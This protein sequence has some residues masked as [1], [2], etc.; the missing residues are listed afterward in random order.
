MSTFEEFRSI[1]PIASLFYPPNLP[2]SS[3]FPPFTPLSPP[4]TLLTSPSL[5]PHFIPPVRPSLHYYLLHAYLRSELPSPPRQPRE[6]HPT[7]PPPPS[8]LLVS[9]SS[10]L[11]RTSHLFFPTGENSHAIGFLSVTSLPDSTN[12]FE[13]ALDHTGDVFKQIEGFKH[14]FHRISSL[15]VS[16]CSGIELGFSS[17]SGSGSS[18]GNQGFE[19]LLLATTL[20]SVNWFRVETGPFQ[21]DC[22]EKERP[23][24]VPLASHGFEN[25]VVHACFSPH[26]REECA[27][28]LDNGE[29]YLFNLVSKKS[30][31][32]RVTLKGGQNPG[33]F[34]GCE[35]G[36]EPWTIIVACAKAIIL[37]DLRDPGEEQT[38]V[39]FKPNKLGTYNVNQLEDSKEKFLVF[40]KSRYSNFHFSVL[41]KFRL[42]LLDLRRPMHPILTWDHGLDHPSYA[43]MFK[44]D[45]LK[46]SSGHETAPQSGFS[47]LAGSL[48]TDEF[49]LFHF[50]LIQK[51]EA[52]GDSPLS[53]WGVPSGIFLSGQC[54]GTSKQLMDKFVSE[55]SAFVK[56]ISCLRKQERVVGFLAI[57]FEDSLTK[58]DSNGFTLIRLMS[59]GRLEV[60]NY[61]P[62]GDIPDNTMSTKDEGMSGSCDILTAC[63]D[64]KRVEVSNRRYC[65]DFR[66]HNA[67][68]HGDLPEILPLDN[69]QS[70]EVS[71]SEDMLALMRDSMNYTPSLAPFID[72]ATIPSSIV[73]IAYQ[74]A[75]NG[76]KPD[77][78][79][80]AFTRYLDIFANK[81]KSNFQLLNV[82]RGSIS[83]DKQPLIVTKPYRRGQ[84][85]SKKTKAPRDKLIGPVLPVPVLLTLEERE[86]MGECSSFTGDGTVIDQK[87]TEVRDSIFPANLSADNEETSENKSFFVYEPQ[88]DFIRSKKLKRG[89]K[90]DCRDEKYEIFVC[91]INTRASCDEVKPDPDAVR[92]ELLDVG[93]IRLGFDPST[94]VVG[95][96]EKGLLEKLKGRYSTWS[97]ENKFY[98]DFCS[99]SK[100]PK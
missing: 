89:D 33:R 92:P 73:E 22:E 67:Y 75:L 91:G 82:S 27:V 60:Q 66:Y 72:N 59:F 7:F 87:C 41:T 96:V 31:K 21:L 29:V 39:L 8:N 51:Q 17:G 85:W 13:L 84:R 94:M 15:S 16:P 12:P 97:S 35:Y 68:F 23:F 38:R 58:P 18:S 83:D 78:L 76:L 6:L 24:L 48:Q 99:S 45:D 28:L 11:P 9:L 37:V 34:I 57:P 77:L 42:M 2:S 65:L 98:Q 30:G 3:S 56:D 81:T 71:L 26:F 49:K 50:G 14:P 10:H 55:K 63:P 36:A 43:T 74:S 62:L 64:C 47:I 52:F 86:K 69:R 79:P 88:C 95:E 32:I 80:L 4:L 25:P 100:L 90:R 20:Y 5:L 40:C 70:C 61:G 44:L 93:P 19:G 46:P 1:F 54:G 53:A